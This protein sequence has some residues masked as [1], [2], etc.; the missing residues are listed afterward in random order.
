MDE[1]AS[2][3]SGELWIGNQTLEQGAL[4]TLTP[5]EFS[6][7]EF[8]GAVSDFGR[9]VDEIMVRADNGVYWTEWER[10]RINTDP[11]GIESIIIQG[12]NWLQYFDGEKTVIPFTFIDGNGEQPPIPTYYP[13]PPDDDHPECNNPE[14]VDNNMRAMIRE[15][16]GY[17]ETVA[18]L[19]FVEVHFIPSAA[20]AI[21][22]FGSFDND[23]PGGVAAH[24][25]LPFDQGFGTFGGD[26]W[27]D[28]NDFPYGA[29]GNRYG[30]R[31]T[32]CDL[33]RSGACHG[34]GAF[35]PCL[36]SLGRF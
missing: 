13:C 28:S 10:V 7:L 6:Q 12:A 29:N 18:D 19:D 8:E 1:N 27:Y 36:A 33:S 9:Q 2:F 35:I 14:P 22:T 5:G 21:M 34:L 17:Y 16:L 30:L 11:V 3:R 23:G 24:A 26:V 4:H 20:N 25:Y 31:G 15:V 32:S